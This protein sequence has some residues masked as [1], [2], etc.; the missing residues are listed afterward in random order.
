MNNIAS[1]APEPMMDLRD[2]FPMQNSRSF[3]PSIDNLEARFDRNRNRLPDFTSGFGISNTQ[4]NDPKLSTFCCLL[5]CL[6]GSL[7]LPRFP[8]L[9]PIPTL[10]F[11]MLERK[12]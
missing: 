4:Q 8:K 1:R 11:G 2:P 3:E 9:A 10:K 12:S 6:S 7:D 5:L